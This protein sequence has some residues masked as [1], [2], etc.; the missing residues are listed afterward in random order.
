MSNL[1]QRS[2]S[3]VVIV[4]GGSVGLRTAFHLGQAGIKCTVIDRG[5]CGGSTSWGNGGWLVPAMTAPLPAPGIALV[6]VR[7]TLKRSAS[8]SVRPDKAVSSIPWLF[9]FMRHCN[10][11]SYARVST[12][13]AHLAE[14][15]HRKFDELMAAGAPLR[16]MKAGN[17]RACASEG[18]AVK[19]LAALVE[20][21]GGRHADGGR[22]ARR[23][24]MEV[25]RADLR[26]NARIVRG[27]MQVAGACLKEW[28]GWLTEADVRKG[29]ENCALASGR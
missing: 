22:S 24:C 27:M 26:P 15:M 2:A 25:G 3:K 5:V 10:K 28:P 17:I 11:S 14:D 7:E 9:K 6:G 23:R 4:G 13:F 1:Y 19:Q 18:D 21:Q 16:L 8:V 20:H 12:A 29:D